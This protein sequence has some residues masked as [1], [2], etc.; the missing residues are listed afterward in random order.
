MFSNN[1]IESKLKTWIFDNVL[2][3]FSLEFSF[4]MLFTF[5]FLFFVVF[6]FFMLII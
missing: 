3:T 5:S 6:F 1:N 4:F 2:L